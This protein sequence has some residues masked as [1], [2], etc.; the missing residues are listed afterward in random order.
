M[1]LPSRRWWGEVYTTRN[2]AR[3]ARRIE[4]QNNQIRPLSRSAGRSTYI[5]L[6]KYLKPVEQ[7]NRFTVKWDFRPRS[8]QYWGYALVSESL[9]L[10]WACKSCFKGLFY[11]M[12]LYFFFPIR[13][14]E[15]WIKRNARIWLSFTRLLPTLLF[16]R[17]HRYSKNKLNKSRNN[18]LCLYNASAIKNVHT[19]TWCFVLCCAGSECACADV[20]TRTFTSSP[21]HTRY[22]HDYDGWM[23]PAN[24]EDNA[25]Y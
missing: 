9:W 24:K 7:S 5:W 10:H 14:E 1:G 12:E 23:T 20:C 13:L 15:L 11:F 25:A 22:C 8:K 3:P 4:F 19:W 16:S 17:S 21:T 18:H 6:Q 2:T